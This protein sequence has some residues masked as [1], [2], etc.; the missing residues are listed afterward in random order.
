MD[1]VAA[2]HLAQKL[3][4]F[5]TPICMRVTTRLMHTFPELAQTLRLEAAASVEARLSEVSV[6][7]LYELV[8]AILMFNLLS[9]ADKELR[10]AQGVLPRSGVTD[11][12]QAAMIR[13]FFEEVR[14]IGLTPTEVAI[15]R[16]IEEYMLDLLATI[17]ASRSR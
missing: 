12:H 17:Y 5:C 7:R 15:T 2:E 9:L 11:K 16:E 4:S 1:S 10:W 13:W 14:E 6:E 8:R 3:S